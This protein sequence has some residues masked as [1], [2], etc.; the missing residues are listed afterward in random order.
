VSCL[1]K[2]EFNILLPFFL[3]ELRD[4]GNFWQLNDFSKRWAWHERL[5][6]IM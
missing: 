3:R 2:W 4:A 5:R 6:R 1:F